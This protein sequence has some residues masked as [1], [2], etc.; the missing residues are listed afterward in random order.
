VGFN[1]VANSRAIGC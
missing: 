1:V